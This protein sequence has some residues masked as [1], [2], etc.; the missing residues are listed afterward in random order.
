MSKT[1]DGISV[2]I[3]AHDAD[4]ARALFDKCMTLAAT[5]ERYRGELVWADPPRG[6]AQL[7]THLSRPSDQN[8]E[9]H[10]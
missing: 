6:C 9:S 5:G 3:A 4:D 10:A 1:T 8:E 7:Y 2:N